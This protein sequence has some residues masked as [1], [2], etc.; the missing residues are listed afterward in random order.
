MA[1]MRYFPVTISASF[2][3]PVTGH[4][5][6]VNRLWPRH[7]RFS[8]LTGSVSGKVGALHTAPNL[9]ATL[10]NFRKRLKHLFHLLAKLLFNCNEIY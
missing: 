2:K 7:N 10:V 3:F 9:Q 8:P 4:Y 1:A 6:P 5:L